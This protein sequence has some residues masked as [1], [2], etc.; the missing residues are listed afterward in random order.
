[1]KRT[2]KGKPGVLAA[3]RQVSKR[4]L[5]TIPSPLPIDGAPT[6]C[7]ELT[8]YDNDGPEG[9]YQRWRFA[10]S[11]EAIKMLFEA[12]D[13]AQLGGWNFTL[14]NHWTRQ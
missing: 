5:H 10:R 9:F 12:F 13:I 14:E 7:V 3:L 1:M 4:P 2:A 6:N 11:S 8:I